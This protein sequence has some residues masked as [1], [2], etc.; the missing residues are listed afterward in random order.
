[1][2]ASLAVTVKVKEVPADAEV[3]APVNTNFV[4]AP[5]DT[6][7]AEDVEV[8][9]FPVAVRVKDPAVFRVT[10]NVFVPATSTAAAGIAPSGSFDVRVTVLVLVVTARR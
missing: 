9:E 7:I 10:L 1:L 3:G 8:I 6:V 4:A 5:A 2:F